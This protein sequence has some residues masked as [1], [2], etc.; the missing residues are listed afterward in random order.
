MRIESQA[1]CV[2]RGGGFDVRHRFVPKGKRLVGADRFRVEIDGLMQRL[3]RIFRAVHLAVE[4]PDPLVHAGI[5]M[6]ARRALEPLHGLFPLSQT[7]QR[8]AP[9]D[10]NGIAAGQQML[11]PAERGDCRLAAVFVN[12]HLRQVEVRPRVVGGLR[13]GVGEELFRIGPGLVTSVA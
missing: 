8:P 4:Q 1:P 2:L 10:L 13:R 7:V 5:R 9:G 11:S 3:A 6:D 12:E